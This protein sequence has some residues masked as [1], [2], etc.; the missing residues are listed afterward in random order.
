MVSVY[1]LHIGGGNL[2]ITHEMRKVSKAGT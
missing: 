1:N 2:V